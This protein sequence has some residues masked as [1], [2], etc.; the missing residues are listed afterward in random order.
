MVTVCQLLAFEGTMIL[1]NITKY[2]PDDIAKYPRR[3]D[4]PVSDLN[5]EV[6]WLS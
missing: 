1:Q 3:L 2:L 4:L 5:Q 6:K